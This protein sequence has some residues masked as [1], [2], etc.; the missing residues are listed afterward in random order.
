MGLI[1]MMLMQYL[2]LMLASIF[3]RNGVHGKGKPPAG[4]NNQRIA[5]GKV[6]PGAAFERML[7]FENPTD[8]QLNVESVQ[9]TPPLIARCL[10]RTVDPG[11]LGHFILTVDNEHVVGDYKGQVRISFYESLEPADYFIDAYFVPAV[12]FKPHPAFFVGTDLGEIEQATIEVINHRSKPLLISGIRHDS[13]RFDMSVETLVPGQHYEV[14]L[15]LLGEAPGEKLSESV[16]LLTG[17]KGKKGMKLLAN[18]WIRERV[19]ALPEVLD[20]GRLPIFA[21]LDAR[22]VAAFAQTLMVY[23]K[24][25]RDFKI[26]VSTDVDF[27]D[28][29]SEQGPKGDRYKLVVALIPGKAPIGNYSGN[30]FICT[31]DDKIKNLTVPIR[32]S[33][34]ESERRS[35]GER[36]KDRDRRTDNDRRTR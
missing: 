8:R 3:R 25:G 7:Y 26:T 19:F 22:K 34:F 21:T 6:M 28:V 35:D 15:T 33:I 36:R 30:L 20:M 31:N 4:K 12:E 5:L 11:G 13:E 32:G 14:T 16:Y 10:T 9:L 24:G 27:V 17:K 1:A 2:S 29:H 23:K 18:T